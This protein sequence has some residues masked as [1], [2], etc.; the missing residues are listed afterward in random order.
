M[1]NVSYAMNC[2][3]AEPFIVYQL[4]SIY[5]H[6]HQIIIVEGAYERFK[7]AATPGGRSQDNTL[8]IINNYP[9][10]QKKLHVIAEYGHFYSGRTDMCNAFMPHVTGDVLWQIDADEFYHGETHE[11]VKRLFA[12][13][14]ELDRISFKIAD[15]WGRSR[16]VVHGYEALGLEDV[17]RVHRVARGDRWITQRP[18]E[19]CDV[20]GCVRSPRK[21][22]SG[23]CMEQ[24]G[25][26]MHHAT[27]FFDKQISDKYKFYSS[28][29]KGVS[30]PSTWMRDVWYEF[31]NHFNVAGFNR[32]VTFLKINEKC[33]PEALQK[34]EADV[35]AGVIAGFQMRDCDDIEQVLS[36]RSYPREVAIAEQ[37][38][39]LKTAGQKYSLTL[40]LPKVSC[41]Y[42]DVFLFL[43][44]KTRIFAA[45]V[46]TVALLKR[47]LKPFREK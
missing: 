17:N 29:W 24:A 38:S 46:V 40:F 33:V 2:I 41:S 28:M 12:E 18:P 27:L 31:A 23:A 13:D 4:D 34:L 19:I 37:V 8:D 1:V 6:A 9:D 36:G 26:L 14:P 25:H 47:L 16:Y 15:Y 42:W 20:N 10:P 3:N 45:K 39:E 44:G 22:L 21:V 32:D 30:K 11:Y 43:R 5:D 7:H 35:D